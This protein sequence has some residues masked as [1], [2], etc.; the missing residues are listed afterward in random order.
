[1]LENIHWVN[2]E[3][4]GTPSER[5]QESAGVRECSPV[6]DQMHDIN[7]TGAEVVD[8]HPYYRQ[9]RALEAWHICMEHQ[10]MNQDEGSCQQ[11]TSPW[12]ARHIHVQSD[13]C[14]QLFHF[15]IPLTYCTCEWTATI[16]ISYFYHHHCMELWCHYHLSLL[17]SPPSTPVTFP[18]VQIYCGKTSCDL[19]TTSGSDTHDWFSSLTF[20]D[21]V[22]SCSHLSLHAWSNH[23][24]HRTLSAS[25]VT[26]CILTSI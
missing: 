1:M 15:S 11:Y 21:P 9:R 4:A 5:A 18:A 7:W 10:A 22:V 17:F 2:R 26:T 12:F 25:F 13:R 8:S 6:S 24:I 16:I 19:A 23:P 20:L 3:D 14:I